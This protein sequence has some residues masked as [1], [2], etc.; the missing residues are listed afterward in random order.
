MCSPPTNIFSDPPFGKLDL[1]CCR[2]RHD[3]FPAGGCG[4]GLFAIF[5]SALKNNGYLFLGKSETAGEYI[6]LFKTGL[7]REKIYLH[8]SEG[9]VEDLTPPTFTIP[10]IQAIT[11]AGIHQAGAAAPDTGRETVYTQFL[12]KF[13][14][15]SVILGPGRY[16]AALFRQLQ[17]L[18]DPGAGQGDTELFLDAA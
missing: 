7:Q 17:R 12:E 15:A 9:K 11:P 18:P 10:N 3:L 8:K 2:K 6:N 13:M 4:R 14:P 1:I 5:H 16:G